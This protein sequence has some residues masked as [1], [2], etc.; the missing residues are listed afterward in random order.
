MRLLTG[1]EC[2]VTAGRAAVN[3]LAVT[4]IVR[5][6][7]PKRR[8]AIDERRGTRSYH[9]PVVLVLHRDNDNLVEIGSNGCRICGV[10]DEGG[11]YDSTY[12]DD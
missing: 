12:E 8:K 10:Y 4:V 7:R 9:R 5:D 2:L 1:S 3:I 11:S 6:S